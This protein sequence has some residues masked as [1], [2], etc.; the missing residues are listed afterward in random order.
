MSDKIKQLAP[1]IWS[2]IQKANK[3][4]LHCHPN[5]DGDTIGGV[6]GM[7][8]ALERL[9]KKVTVIWGDST[10]DKSLGLLPGFAE[11]VQKNIFEINLT[12]FDLFIIQDSSSLKQISDKGEINF[13]KS[14][15]TVVIDHHVTNTNFAQVNLVDPNYSSVCEM[16]FDLLKFW[17]I[18]MTRD[19]GLCLFIGIYTDT[20]GFKYPLV[21]ENTFTAAAEIAKLGVDFS[22]AIFEMENNLEPKSIKLLGA[23]YSNIEHYFEG[24]VAIC[25]IST[26]K[27]NKLGIPLDIGIPEISNTIKSGIGNNIGIFMIEK[28]G[29]TR[30]SMRTRQPHKFD[31]GKIALA[32]G[33]GGGHPVAAGAR[34]P[35]S[36][37]KSK[38]LILQTIQKVYPDLGQP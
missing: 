9:K 3:I 34:I 4:L 1:Q 13:P 6:L 36:I 32:T 21:T 33:Y 38:K 27:L 16:V 8:H 2:E 23:I 35:M 26:N 31:L 24:N 28:N 12:E 25:S 20:G 37:S 10:P 18:E 5:A 17:N 22:S 15:K 29:Y 7:K 19:I 30:T 11:I 14:L